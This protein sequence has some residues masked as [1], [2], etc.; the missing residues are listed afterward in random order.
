L[1]LNGPSDV[2]NHMWFKYTDWQGIIDK[3][4]QAPFKPS[5]FISN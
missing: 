3:K 4:V 5:K 1:G 2:K